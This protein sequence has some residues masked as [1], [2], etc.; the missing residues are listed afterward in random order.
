MNAERKRADGSEG[1]EWKNVTLHEMKAF[2]G[3]NIAMGV[4]KLP[5]AR[6]YWQQRWL[7][8]VPFCQVMARNCFFQILRYLHVLDDVNIVPAGMPGCDK[9]HKIKPLLSLLFPRI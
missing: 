4:V 6:M 8:N 5:G 3:L 2:F 7:R 9:L 1:G